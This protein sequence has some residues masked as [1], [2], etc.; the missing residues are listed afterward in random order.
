MSELLPEGWSTKSLGELAQVVSGGTPSRNVPYFWD[1]GTIPW[2]T[3]TDITATQGKYISDSKDKITKLGLMGCSASLLPSGSIL[4]TSR[5]TLGEA[6][7]SKMAACT[8]QGFK[9]LVAKPGISTEFLYYQLQ[10][11]KQQYARFGSGSTFLEVGKRDTDAFPVLIPGEANQRK[12]AEVLSLIDTQIEA[13]ETLIAKQERVRAGLM[14][15]LFTRGV[16]EQGQL[17]P[18]CEQAPHLYHQTELGRLPL[19]WEVKSVANVTES[20]IDGPFGS[21]LKSEHYVDEP[22]VRVVRLQNI[23]VGF[24]DNRD[25]AYVSER[26][27]LLLARFSV[28][29]KDVLIASLGDDRF[30]AGRACCYP[31]DLGPA[32]NKADCFRVRAERSQALPEFLMLTFNSERMRPELTKLIQGVT[33]QRINVGNF[34][35]LSVAMPDLSEQNAIVEGFESATKPILELNAELSELQR[36]KSG[37]MQDLL[38]GKVPV[39]P[40]LEGRTREGAAA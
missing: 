19:G 27:A 12:I 25:S 11:T 4:M 14:Q 21:N 9:S 17:R 10:R 31:S 3:P 24:Y 20:V 29:P 16:D 35:R 28:L 23:Q 37:L 1:E 7:I 22:G 39:T 8:N 6:K 32:I 36:L 38:N 15:D 33:R 2:V 13:T 5:A 34:K 18:P 26:H 40:L 30:Q